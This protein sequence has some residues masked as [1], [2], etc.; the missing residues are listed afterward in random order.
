MLNQPCVE[1]NDGRRIPQLGL[2]VWQA[3][4]KQVVIAIEAALEA[5]YRSIDTAAIYEN[6]EGVGHAL[7][8]CA[9]PREELFITTKLWN[10][11]HGADAPRQALET[12][13]KKLKL[14][15][16]DLYLIHWP[17]PQRDDQVATWQALIKLQ[18][19]GLAKSIGV[20]NFHPHHLQKLLNATGKAPVINQ[21][22]LHP[23]F[24]QRPLRA[25]DAGHQIVTES[26]SPLA[27]G[28]NTLFKHPTIMQLAQKYQKSAAQI[29]LRWHLDSGLVV[30]P[31]SVTPARIRENFAI[32]DFH[33]THDELAQMEK[34]DQ[35]RR[36]GP[37]P[38]TFDMVKIN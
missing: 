18:E 5:G 33:L 24:Q 30:I 38:E 26:W 35:N 29:I 36:I 2:G 19:Q 1:L 34:I 27:R 11:S 4:N 28:D 32:L 16:V 6:E 23:L 12:S 22:E 17:L 31:K 37:D 20:S 8:N 9:L 25:F 14:D 21:V 13:L 10:D 15:Y 7:Q 3:D